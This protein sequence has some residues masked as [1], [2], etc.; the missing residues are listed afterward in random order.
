M[1]CDDEI[2][3]ALAMLGNDNDLH[4]DACSQLECFVC[5]LYRSKIHTTVKELRWFLYS[6]RAAEGENLLPTSG[7]LDF[8]H[9]RCAH[10]T[11][12]LWRKADENH[13]CLPA[14]ASFGWTFDA[15]SSHFSPVRC[16]NKPAPEAILHLINC[17]CKSGCEGRCSCRKKT[18]SHVI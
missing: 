5:V 4:S 18:I 17:G 8:K 1:S 11:A 12:I 7:S 10:Y 6:N 3:D 16:L 15:G 2:L 13:P 9:I 14:P